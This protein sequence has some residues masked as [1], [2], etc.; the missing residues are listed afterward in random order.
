MSISMTIRKNAVTI[1]IFGKGEF[2]F[3]FYF[4]LF[5]CCFLKRQFFFGEQINDIFL[6]YLQIP[7]VKPQC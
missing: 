7:Y 1:M 4:I 6:S 2:L 3:Y 5:Y